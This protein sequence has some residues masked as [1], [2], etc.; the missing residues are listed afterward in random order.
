MS[1]NNETPKS[2]GGRPKK[3]AKSFNF[4]KRKKLN[5]DCS[6]E[7]SDWNYS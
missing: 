2:K 5:Y 3:G 1:E 7:T 6:E 4:L